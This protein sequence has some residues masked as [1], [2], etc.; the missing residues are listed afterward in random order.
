MN[1][2]YVTSVM[3]A[4]IVPVLIPPLSAGT[5][6]NNEE[7]GAEVAACIHGLVLTGGGDIDPALFN[8]PGA[9]SVQNVQRDRDETEMALLRSAL[10]LGMPV[11]GICRGMQLINV[12]LGGDLIVDIKTEYL[13]SVAH[14]VDDD[15][16]RH[17]VRIASDSKISRI[18]D[19]C[20]LNTNSHHHQAVRR[21]AAGLVAVGWAEDGIIEALE[22]KGENYLVGVQWHPERLREES[23]ARLFA[24]FLEAAR[25]YRRRRDSVERTGRT[26]GRS[27]SR[28][29]R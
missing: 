25:D 4:G 10:K 23:S 27:D 9:A 21:V 15:S 3:E 6:K 17:P 16:V 18:L 19:T 20:E 22:G 2:S 8:R 1:T 11:L 7:G 14:D 24:S 29:D 12:A 26:A 28:A 5:V 13:T